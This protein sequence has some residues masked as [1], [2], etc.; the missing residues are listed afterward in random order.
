MG[1]RVDLARNGE[2]AIA[3]VSRSLSEG[4]PCDLLIMDL[5]IRGGLWEA[6]TPCRRS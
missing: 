1:H 4:S 6:R 2:E 5:T 3:Q